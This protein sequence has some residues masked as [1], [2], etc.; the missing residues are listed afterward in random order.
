MTIIYADVHNHILYADTTI[1]YDDGRKPKPGLTK[2]RWIGGKV[3]S[4]AIAICG[5]TALASAITEA[6]AGHFN[7]MEIAAANIKLD[8]FKEEEY[9][10]GFIMTP[11]CFWVVLFGHGVITIIRCTEDVNNVTGSGSAWF[12]AYVSAGASPEAAFDMVC[13]YHGECGYPV[14]QVVLVH[15]TQNG[16]SS[17]TLLSFRHTRLPV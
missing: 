5:L 10:D 17:D 9:A 3:G 12:H 13:R 11:D 6:I 2:I 14:D 15:E 8:G 7:G 1:S 4:N 16:E